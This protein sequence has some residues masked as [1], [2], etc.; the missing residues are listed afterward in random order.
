MNALNVIGV[1]LVLLGVVGALGFLGEAN[2]ISFISDPLFNLTLLFLTELASLIFWI[3][4][5]ILGLSVAT[6][7][8]GYIKTIIRR[9]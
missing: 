4:V 2:P 9:R 7:R 3:I 1:L 5:M 8:G 6:P